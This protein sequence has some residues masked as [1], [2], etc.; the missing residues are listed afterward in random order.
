MSELE[1]AVLREFLSDYRRLICLT[2]LGL[3]TLSDRRL[4]MEI[5][6][7]CGF[8]RAAC[9]KLKR[10]LSSTEGETHAVYSVHLDQNGLRDFCHGRQY[11]PD[12]CALS[13]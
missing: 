5:E 1:R 3:P 13:N 4:A 10:V 6:L 8:G 11:G 9:G 12:H 7:L 2:E